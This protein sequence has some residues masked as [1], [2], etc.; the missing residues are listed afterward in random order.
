MKLNN[1]KDKENVY[2]TV[3]SPTV[4]T[5]NNEIRIKISDFVL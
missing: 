5:Y 4:S 3:C 1:L 2:L